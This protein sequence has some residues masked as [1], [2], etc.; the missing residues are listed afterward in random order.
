MAM[1]AKLLERFGHNN[2]AI[3]TSKAS[4]ISVNNCS[5]LETNP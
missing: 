3:S 5:R 2:S 4:S 1:P